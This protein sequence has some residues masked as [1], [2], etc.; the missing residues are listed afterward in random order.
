MK[1]RKKSKKPVS[2]YRLDVSGVEVEVVRKDIKNLRMVVYPPD[3]QV[4]VSVPLRVND[5][6]VRATVIERMEWIQKHQ[7][8]FKDQE[9][10]P[11]LQFITGENV[12]VF[13]KAYR[14]EVIERYGAVSVRLVDNFSL[15]MRLRP[16][17][18]AGQRAAILDEWYRQQLRERAPDLI[19][20]WEPV[21]GVSVAEWRIRKM[22]TR[23][24]TCNVGAR[25]IWLNVELAR[26]PL[27]CLEFIVVHEM[28]HLLERLHN[29]RF[30]GLMDGFMPEWRRWQGELEREP[31]P[32]SP[33]G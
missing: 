21:I 10:R 12:L 6:A 20:K 3:G 18:T 1:L 7:R 31:F 14:L 33:L 15:E 11:E 8:R 16:N 29:A 24:G 22:K 4:R 28:V 13:G 23:W 27:G 17:S 25:R 5:D 26:R 2:R 9:R 32:P 19:A 30:K